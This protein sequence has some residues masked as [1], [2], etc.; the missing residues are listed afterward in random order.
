MKVGTTALQGTMSA[1]DMT[2]QAKQLKN[3]MDITR[4]NVVTMKNLSL[5]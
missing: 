1:K 2:S 4:N 3:E 5:E